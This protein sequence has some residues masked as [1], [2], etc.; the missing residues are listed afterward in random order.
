MGHLLMDLAGIEC[1]IAGLA[2]AAGLEAERAQALFRAAHYLR[3]R[4]SETAGQGAPKS[5]QRK[6]FRAWLRGAT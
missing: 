4:A 3:L 6:R 5:E 1:R 2:A